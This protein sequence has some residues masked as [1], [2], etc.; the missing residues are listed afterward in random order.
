MAVDASHSRFLEDPNRCILCTRCVRACAE[1]EGAHV[2]DVGGRGIHS[3]IISDLDDPWGQSEACT[4]CGKCVQVCPTGA[5][6]EKG[7]A[8]GEMQKRSRDLTD[9]TRMRGVRS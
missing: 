8:T 7:R 5:L 2:W 9:L 6:S 1:V 3:R 4:A